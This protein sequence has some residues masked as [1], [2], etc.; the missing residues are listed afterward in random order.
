MQKSEGGSWELDW[1]IWIGLDWIGLDNLD[2]IGVDWGAWRGGDCSIGI[3]DCTVAGVRVG[4]GSESGSGEW[5]GME[6][7]GVDR[8]MG[9]SQWGMYLCTVTAVSGFRLGD[10][11]SSREGLFCFC[12]RG[13]VDEEGWG[14]FEPPSDDLE[15]CTLEKL[16]GIVRGSR[17]A[18]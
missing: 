6:W 12:G 4:C 9:R 13:A 18:R 11:D 7:N 1:I 14:W 15:G 8:G 3:W 5:N 16:Q 2:W 17:W 10:S